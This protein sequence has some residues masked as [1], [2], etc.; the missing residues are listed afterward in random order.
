MFIYTCFL[1]ET[2][3]WTNFLLGTQFFEL[4]ILL[5][6]PIGHVKTMGAQTQSTRPI[7]TQKE[8]LL[9]VTFYLNSSYNFIVNVLPSKVFAMRLY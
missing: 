5:A 1:N 8:T 2:Q 6:R 9:F 3:G 4:T 7:D